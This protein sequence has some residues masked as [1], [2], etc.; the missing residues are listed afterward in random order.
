VTVICTTEAG[1]PRV[2]RR[3]ASFSFA[4]TGSIA[5]HRS[6]VMPAVAQGACAVR[7]RA[8]VLGEGDIECGPFGAKM[9]TNVFRGSGQATCSTG[10]AYPVAPAHECR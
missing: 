8:L 6:R 1:S 10:A 2:P 7:F 5:R 9:R 4:I 3:S